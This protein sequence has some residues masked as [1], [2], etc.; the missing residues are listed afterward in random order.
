[1]ERVTQDDMVAHLRLRL[2]D[3]RPGQTLLAACRLMRMSIRI[4]TV[5]DRW[6]LQKSRENSAEARVAMGTVLIEHPQYC[7]TE[8]PHCPDPT[9]IFS[10][11]REAQ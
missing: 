8:L 4:D 6:I 2:L 1:M 9:R 11:L 5:A 3:R 7:T 10:I